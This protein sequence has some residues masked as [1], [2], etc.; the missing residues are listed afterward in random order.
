MKP[1]KAFIDWVKF[2][3]LHILRNVY[4]SLTLF[5]AILIISLAINEVDMKK[6]IALS[7]F[8]AAWV[9]VYNVGDRIAAVN[10]FSFN[11]PR[12]F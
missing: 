2:I 9:N 11:C 4:I 12:V 10:F 7:N 5:T 1:K 8:E 6:I 3:P